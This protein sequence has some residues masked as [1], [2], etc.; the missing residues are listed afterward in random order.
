MASLEVR[1]VFDR[2]P[3]N[4]FLD[5][6]RANGKE[7]TMTGMGIKKGAF[8]IS[9]AD[10]PEFLNHLHYYLFEKKQIPMNFVEQSRSDS[11]KP[12][13]IDLDFKYPVTA[14]HTRKFTESHIKGFIHQVVEGLK[15]FFDLSSYEEG[16]RMF[17]TLRQGPYKAPNGILKDGIH[18]E[19][20]DLCLSNEKQK[21]LRNWLMEA[22]AVMSAFEGTGFCNTPE[23][24]YDS[25]MV[26][27]QG[28]FFYGESK[29][30]IDP[31]KL[32][33]VYA[34]E[35]LNDEIVER[36]VS[37]YTPRELMELLSIRY[38]L[39]PDDN[40]V[41]ADAKDLYAVGWP[42]RPLLLSTWEPLHLQA[43]LR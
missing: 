24:I 38:N 2:H 28:W 16:I 18:I 9:D 1:D 14:N 4:A 19:C 23:D 37:V 5:A 29:P 3:L 22:R 10:Y 25:S 8:H 32:T 36:D 15:A 30:S 26:R 40:E 21:V 33:H 7:P 39:M 41:R 31:Y 20:P 13:L 27:K 12:I 35:P 17:V 43:N 42:L 6:R 11:A 34:Y